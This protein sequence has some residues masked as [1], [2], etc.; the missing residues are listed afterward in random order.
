[1]N[2]CITSGQRRPRK[3]PYYRSA[4]YIQVPKKEELFLVEPK[5]WYW[6]PKTKKWKLLIID[7]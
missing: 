3:H 4:A 1:M 5:I 6:V 2:H 7:Q